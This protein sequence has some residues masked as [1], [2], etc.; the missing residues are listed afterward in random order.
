M[1]KTIRQLFPGITED[2]Y[3]TYDTVLRTGKPIRFERELV[4][5]ERWLELHVFPVTGSSHRRLAIIFKDITQRALAEQTLREAEAFNRSI[6]ASSPN[7]IKILDLDGKLLSIVTGKHL[8][9]IEDTQPVLNKSWLDFWGQGHKPAAQAAIKVALAGGKG[10][11]VGVFVT[12]SGQAKWWDVVI[13]PILD[14]HGQPVNLLAVS[15]EITQRKQ[16]EMNLEFLS[17]I[18]QDLVTWNSVDEM[19]RAVGEKLAAHLQLSVCA[20]AE[21]KETAE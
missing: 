5:R 18:S 6:I 21:I 2:W 8:L 20:F 3:L 16:A 12:S 9:G 13:T 14:A 1:G 4:P 7:C 11:F 15:R 19:M 10:D 17:S